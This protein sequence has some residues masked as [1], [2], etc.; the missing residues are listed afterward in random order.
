MKCRKLIRSVLALAL[1]FGMLGSAF[2][3]YA[4]ED[5]MYEYEVD[6]Q[7]DACML[8]RLLPVVVKEF[9]MNAVE[10]NKAFF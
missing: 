5:V 6:I 1:S 3:V 4:D 7:E 8:V 9:A 10:G 2:S